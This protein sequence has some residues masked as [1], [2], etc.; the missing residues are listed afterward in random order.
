MSTI[1]ELAQQRHRI[2]QLIEATAKAYYVLK[3][4]TVATIPVYEKSLNDYVASMQATER[5]IDDYVRR[6]SWD[7]M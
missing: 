7:R 6:K 5:E 2:S 4:N 1:D 3:V